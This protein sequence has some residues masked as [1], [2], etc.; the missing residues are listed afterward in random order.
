[1][2]ARLF[3]V[4]ADASV[5]AAK[6]LNAV[7]AAAHGTERELE[8]GKFWAGVHFRMTGELP[9][10]REEAERRGVEW[11]EDSLENVL[12]GGEALPVGGPAGYSR[13]I[14]APKVKQLAGLLEAHSVADFSDGF[15][16]DDLND[17][18]IPPG[19]WHPEQLEL[20]A[21]LYGRLRAFYREAARNDQSI[22]V[23]IE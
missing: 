16:I 4:P 19:G 3:R 8:L 5:G 11:F 6:D 12:F 20:L 13:R 21:D 17:E 9:I 22:V 18:Q 15:E 14:P 7:I 10:P 23:V 1:M 2:N